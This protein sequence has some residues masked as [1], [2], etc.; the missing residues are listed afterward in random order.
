M[1]KA[2][3][4]RATKCEPEASICRFDLAAAQRKSADKAGAEAT[5]KQLRESP[6]RDPATVYAIAHLPKP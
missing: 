5:E 1:L 2:A 4:R 6:T 3:D